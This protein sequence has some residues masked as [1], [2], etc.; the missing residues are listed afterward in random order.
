[1]KSE[2]FETNKPGDTAKVAIS[3]ANDITNRDPGRGALVLGL[4]GELGAG[5]TTFI[6]SFIR[7]LGV[8]K[9]ITSPTFLIS[10]RFNLPNGGRYK[11]V[12]HIDVYRISSKTELSDIGI[13]N[14]INDHNNIVLVE[15][16]DRIQTVLPKET[17]WIKFKH[18]KREN[19]RHITIN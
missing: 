11:N 14:V 17:I 6:K 8:R 16:A 4:I 10:R 18:G 1:M 3:L 7:A 2:L 19:Q 12:F 5:K 15:W 13:N 9:K